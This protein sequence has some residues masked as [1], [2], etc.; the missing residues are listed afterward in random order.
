[1][2]ASYADPDCPDCG[3]H[4]FIYGESM[5]DGGRTC[6]C[7]M[8][9]LKRQNMERIWPSL[10]KAPEIPGLREKPPL[11]SLL[12]RNIWITAKEGVLRAHIKALAYTQSEMW[13]VLV[14]SD[15]DLVDTWLATAKAQGHKIFDTEIADRK[16]RFA[17]M[18][19]AELVEPPD[20]VIFKLG[21]KQAPNKETN[22]VLLESVN[23]RRHLGRPTW[24]IDQPDHRI[25]SD[26]HKG[27]SDLLHGLISHWPHIGLRSGDAFLI[28][29]GSQEDD[30]LQ[31]VS[32]YVVDDIVEARGEVEDDASAQ[33]EDALSDLD[34][35]DTDE[36]GEALDEEGED[37]ELDEDEE[38]GE[39]EELDEDEEEEGDEEEE[40]EEEYEE[41]ESPM[42]SFVAQMEANEEKAAQKERRSRYSKKPPKFKKWSRK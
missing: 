19:I 17:A 30:G 34:D 4:G 13:D 5:L 38:E 22:S 8:D 3:G 39:D 1:V 42:N 7:M 29:A 11:R 14:I 27:Y 41:D 25:D 23:L 15:A 16:S 20:L 28:T 9:A 35:E 26:F 37:E 36:E 21:V 32:D 24:I 6:H 2:S 33:I 18:A 12:K 40:D 31:V 10:S